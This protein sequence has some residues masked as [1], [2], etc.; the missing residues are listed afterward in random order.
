MSEPQNEPDN[1]VETEAAQPEEVEKTVVMEAIP[2]S[3]IPAPA[4][5]TADEKNW[6][7]LCHVSAFCQLL[8]IPAIIGPL[9]IWLIKKD[10]MPIVDTHGKEA[11]NFQLS[12]LIYGLVAGLLCVVLIGILLLPII[13][14]LWLIFTI[15]ASV[16]A[17][18]GEL[19]RYP[20]TI[21]FLK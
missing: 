17:S 20:M 10:E 11:V 8:G 12:F 15:I 14:I 2:E 6:C 3:E 7:M 21:R 19:Y 9:V 18:N 13:G 5:P 1:A 16:K 4:A